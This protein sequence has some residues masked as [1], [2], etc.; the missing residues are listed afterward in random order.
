MGLGINHG[1]KLKNECYDKKE[2]GI[3]LDTEKK[4]ETSYDKLHNISRVAVL[5]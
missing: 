4:Q 5:P 3:I 2:K 1:E